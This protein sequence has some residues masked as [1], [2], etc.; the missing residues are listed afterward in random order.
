MEKLVGNFKNR[1][2][3][4]DITK[5][6]Y[7]LFSSLSLSKFI[8][9]IYIASISLILVHLKETFEISYKIQSL[10]LFLVR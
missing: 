2:N 5:N 1:I 7:Y 3:I 8:L 10:F 9:G 4:I 6:R